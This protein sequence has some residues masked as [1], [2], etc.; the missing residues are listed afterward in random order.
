MLLPVMLGMTDEST[1]AVVASNTGLG[2]E[3]PAT[4][5]Q[6]EQ[7]RESIAFAPPILAHSVI[8]SVVGLIARGGSGKAT[9]GLGLGAEECGGA[10]GEPET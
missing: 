3:Y 5:T 7:T 2:N 9:H 4:V 1:S 10:T 6:P 8:A